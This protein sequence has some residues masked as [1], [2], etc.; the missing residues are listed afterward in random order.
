MLSRPAISWFILWV[1]AGCVHQRPTSERAKCV[2]LVAVGDI[3]LD[4]GV[5]KTAWIEGDPRYPLRHLPEI[6]SGADIAMA[7]LEGPLTGRNT[8]VAK[9]FVFRGD[10]AYAGYLKNAGLNLITLANNHSYDHG[11]QA[12]METIRLFQKEGVT[13]IGAGANHE[14]ASRPRFLEFNGLTIAVLGFVT[15]PLEGIIWLPEKP[16]PASVVDEVVVRSLKEAREKADFVVVSV[17]WGTEYSPLPDPDQLRWA[18]FFREHGADVVIGHHPHVVQPVEEVNGKWVFY[19]LGN[20]IFD[21]KLEP[22]NLAIAARITFCREC[23][24]QVAAVPLEIIHTRPTR[25]GVRAREKIIDQLR[26][27]SRGL[28]FTLNGGTIE[29]R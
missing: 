26:C 4:R 14:E 2:T 21:Q 16:T 25:A 1:F 17:H 19:S 5:A 3:L 27:N 29:I 22:R 9:V 23:P 13:T 28:I 7:N 10:P 6:F 8:P 11:R 24:L 12:L 20:F 18:T 15:M